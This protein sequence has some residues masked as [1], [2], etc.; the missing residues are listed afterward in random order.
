MLLDRPNSNDCH[1]FFIFVISV[2]LFFTTLT[3]SVSKIHL[4]SQMPS[5]SHLPT[6]DCPIH[7]KI[8]LPTYT[9]HVAD[10]KKISSPARLKHSNYLHYQTPLTSVDHSSIT[11]TVENYQNC[12]KLPKNPKIMYKKTIDISVSAIYYRDSF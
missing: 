6:K 9:P 11:Q 10:R 7:N 3:R 8:R 2:S 1:F 12:G 5:S 4:K